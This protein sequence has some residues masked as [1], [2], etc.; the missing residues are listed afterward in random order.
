[1][2]KMSL[3]IIT[4]AGNVQEGAVIMASTAPERKTL[5]FNCLEV[6]LKYL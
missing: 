5:N 2:E 4:G 3:D 6:S 1:M